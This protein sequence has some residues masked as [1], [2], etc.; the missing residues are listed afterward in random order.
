MGGV[1]P[2]CILE[3]RKSVLNL[4]GCEYEIRQLF[5]LRFGK[6]VSQTQKS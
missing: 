2:L 1:C 4:K 6:E 5:N 3:E